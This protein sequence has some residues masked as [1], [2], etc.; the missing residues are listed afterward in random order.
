MKFL[1]GIAAII[2]LLA[3][4]GCGG[5][6]AA[7]SAEKKQDPRFATITGLNGK[8]RPTIKPSD[9]PPPKKVLQR[10]LKAG[11]GPVA[12][13]GDWVTIN[14][15]G[16]NYKTGKEQYGRWPPDVPLYRLWGYGEDGVGWEEGIKGMR[17]G[18]VRELVIPSHLLYE[19]GTIDY[20]VEL[21][22]VNPAD[23]KE[24]GNKGGR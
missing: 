17:E 19:N 16:V 9:L 4:G 3:L 12:H 13:R 22:R 1:I 23:E 24:S 15:V 11:S 2:L 10:D 18:D 6:D 5:D 21:A 8:G 20:V 7:T 14:Y